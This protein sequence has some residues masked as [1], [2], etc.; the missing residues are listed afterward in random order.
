MAKIIHRLANDARVCHLGRTSAPRTYMQ[1]KIMNLMVKN[2]EDFPRRIALLDALHM[3]ILNAKL[4]CR[5]PPIDLVAGQF[6]VTPG[7]EETF[8][9]MAAEHG[10]NASEVT[11]C[12]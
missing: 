8:K 11:E 10:L 4:Y 12:L 9:E 2:R 6:E 3:D 1:T 5:M 7:F